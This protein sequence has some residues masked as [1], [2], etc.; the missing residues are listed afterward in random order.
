MTKYRE[1]LRLKSL[2]FSERSIAQ[3]AGVSRN[4]V[5]KVLKR[6]DELNLKWPLDFGM[7]DNALEEIMFPKEKMK[8]TGCFAAPVR[9]QGSTVPDVRDA[10][11]R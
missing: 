2:G 7:T 10:A 6:A 4:T 3:S 11:F 1:I 5:S 9:P 8:I